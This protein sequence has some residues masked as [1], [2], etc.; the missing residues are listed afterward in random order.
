MSEVRGL[1][2]IALVSVVDYDVLYPA[3]QLTIS[4]LISFLLWQD[5][6]LKT[7]LDDG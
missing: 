3:L 4:H 1:Y 5:G 2:G 6:K 7:K